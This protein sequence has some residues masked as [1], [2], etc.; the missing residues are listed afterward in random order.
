M[1]TT[2][3]C[4][5]V[6]VV[7]LIVGTVLMAETAGTAFTYQ[8]RL[9]D[10]NIA[11]D[12]VYDMRF[13][14][15]D[16]PNILTATQIGST[17]T[18]DDVDVV[19]G[20]FV[21]ELD[22]GGDVYGD[23]AR[24]MQVAVRPGASMDPND[25]IALSPLQK[26]SA[27]PYA[28]SAYEVTGRVQTPGITET[29]FND[30]NTWTPKAT[31]QYWWSV[32]M[33]ADGGVQTAVYS[34]GR[35]YVSTDYWDTWTSHES[36]RSWSSVAMSAD[37]SI[38]T[39]VATG[40][41]IYVST[42]TGNTW[43][44]KG[45]GQN[46]YSVAMSADGSIQTAVVDG[47]QIF[48][49][50]DTGNTWTPKGAVRGWCS[51]AMSADGSVQTAVYNGGR[52]Y[53]STDYWDT[54]TSHDSNRSW[55]SV[56]VSSDGS[57][58]TAV[59]YNG[60]IYISTPYSLVIGIGTTNPTAELEVVGTVK[61]TAFTGDGSG[62]TNIT[63]VEW[64]NIMSRPS[65]LDD[66]DDVG[67]TTESDPQVGVIDANAV[68][69]WDGSALVTGTI[70]DDGNVGVGT[71]MPAAKLDVNGTAKA[72]NFNGVPWRSVGWIVSN[73]GPGD[74]CYL[75]PGIAVAGWNF[76]QYALP[77]D[78]TIE[79]VIISADEEANGSSF[80]MELYVNGS[81]AATSAAS[82]VPDYGSVIQAFPSPVNTASGTN[83]T[84]K[85]GTG[86]NAAELA[87]WLYGRTNE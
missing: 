69:K 11:A 37:G 19:D 52:I 21:A 62:L 26:M 81:Q 32:A 34:G 38:Q 63:G 55:T 46:W 6:F 76:Y 70:Y 20:Y 42:D 36:N 27:A 57:I 33:S 10:D 61:A 65:G 77:F 3:F 16:D 18:A 83:I 67:I 13:T 59:A 74:Q 87:V 40:G 64:T 35:I 22:F 41:Q 1:K 49:S 23:Q 25:F 80:S 84:V 71:I 7:I 86:N 8:G 12:G 51:V 43:T 60:Q 79:G 47:G 15:Y 73:A 44:P 66:G 31:A 50:T 56:A 9:L 17:V 5:T 58:Q 72:N 45:T 48:V 30:Y 82:S 78:I 85:C 75:A 54:W 2:T 39:A 28:N 24:W 29:L 4:F 68:P 14:L 53:V